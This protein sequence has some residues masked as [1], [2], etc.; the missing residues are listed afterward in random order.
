MNFVRKKPDAGPPSKSPQASG[1]IHG[2]WRTIRFAALAASLFLAG[3]QTTTQWSLFASPTSAPAK[4]VEIDKT[5][6][7]L[8]AYEADRLVLLSRVSTGR[9]GHRTPSG[10]FQAGAKH[11]MHYSRLYHNAPMPFSVQVSGNYF[12]HGYHEV[13][14]YP[15]SHGCIRMP[16]DGDNPAQRFYQWVDAGTP[17]EIRGE[18][19]GK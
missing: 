18:W 7:T 15:A 1:S 5:T 2:A 17:I 16:L 6:Q 11:L 14:A 19:A 4:R 3:C 13:P 8:K 10:S 12:I 9:A